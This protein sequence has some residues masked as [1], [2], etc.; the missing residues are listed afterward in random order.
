M[1]PLRCDWVI[2]PVKIVPEMTYKVSSGTLNLCSIN[3]YIECTTTDD[4]VVWFISQ[5]VVQLCC[6]K[7]AGWIK[8][9]F[10]ME[11]LG[12]QTYCIIWGSCALCGDGRGSAGKFCPLQSIGILFTFIE[13]F[14]KL[15]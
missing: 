5:S 9:L 12:A 3:Q 6:A 4:L 2:W 13:A 11:T 14:A 1:G 8:V 7:A 10:G 15:L